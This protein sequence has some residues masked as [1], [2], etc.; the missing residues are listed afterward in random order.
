MSQSLAVGGGAGGGALRRRGRDTLPPHEGWSVLWSQKWR[1]LGGIWE[2]G[3]LSCKQRT[4]DHHWLLEGTAHITAEHLQ[5]SK[6]NQPWQKLSPGTVAVWGLFC[7]A[8]LS[9]WSV[10][11]S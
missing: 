3:A 9:P 7:A 2:G 11:S 10:P 8:L 6:S 5:T 1:L 4:A